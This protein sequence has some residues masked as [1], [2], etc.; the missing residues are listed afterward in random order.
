MFSA[1]ICKRNC[2]HSFGSFYAKTY[3]IGICC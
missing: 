2:Q 3:T 1:V